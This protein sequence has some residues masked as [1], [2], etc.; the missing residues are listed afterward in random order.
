MDVAAVK[1][2]IPPEQAAQLARSHA[3]GDA[4]PTWWVLCGDVPGGDDEEWNNAVKIILEGIATK[5][6]PVAMQ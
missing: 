3:S 1:I 6:L 5:K 2:D 4:S